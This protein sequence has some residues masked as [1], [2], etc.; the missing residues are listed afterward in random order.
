MRILFLTQ[1]F[2]P[3]PFYKG[4][5]FVKALKQI[6]HEVEVLT[7]VPNYPEGKLYKGYN[8]RLFQR[9]IIEG[10]PVMRVPL[11]PSHDTSSIKRIINY[12]S[13][14]V[15][16][17]II[18]LFNINKPD[19]IYV[20]HP[21]ATIGFSALVLS[22][23]YRAPFVYDIQDLWPDTL[24]A[25]GMLNNQKILKIIDRYCRIIYSRASRIV[26]LSQGFKK[27]LISRG[28]PSSK[29]DVIYNWCDEKQTKNFE[30][31]EYLRK[32]YSLA[33]K[34]NIVFAGTMGKA[35]ALSSMLDVAVKL[36]D[37]F[38]DIQFVFIGEGIE[39]ERLKKKKLKLNL[40]NVIF[41][42]RQPVSKI[43][44]FLDMADVLLV[45]LKNDPL[46][47]ITIPSKTQAYM[48]A[49]KP[50]LMAV[51]GDA[52]ELINTSR[53]GVVCEPE[54]VED[55]A[56]CIISLY[57]MP[58]SALKNMGTNGKDYYNKN[59]SFDIGVE[60]FNSVFKDVVKEWQVK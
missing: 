45:H 43:G 55:I 37:S 35:Q 47:T 57:R 26:V 16:A 41:I 18:G 24:I 34:F 50:I 52:A 3:E 58:R 33:G 25:T 53:S 11:Y 2:Q 60:K 42:P 54:N 8:V 14:A 56:Q 17:A 9:E 15:S 28:V 19:L 27:L 12:T 10:I 40:R 6:G 1:W 22:L 48:A 13:F 7:G 39:T 59:L 30:S 38:S 46:F 20:Y 44:R 4:I 21:P 36:Q 31:A 32:Q 5:P 29:I 23:I 49:G 51:K